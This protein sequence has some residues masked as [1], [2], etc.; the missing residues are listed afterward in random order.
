MNV[1]M[2]EATFGSEM[3]R[4]SVERRDRKTLSI[5]VLP[6]QTVEVLAPVDAS[7]ERIIERVRRRG[8]WI[9][10]QLRYFDQFQPRTP[11]RRYLAGETHLYLGRQYKLKVLPGIRNLVKMQRGQIIIWSTR[12]QR[13]EQTR[14]LMR[15]WFLQR[16]RVKFAERLTISQNRFANPERMAPHGLVIRDLSHRWGSMTKRRNLVLNRALIGASTEAIDYVITHELCHIEHP[17][18]GREFFD[19]L[20]RVMPDWEKRKLKLERQ[21]A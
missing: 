5:S 8:A 7:P 20:R 1:E 15:D 2:L 19:L 12:A 9:R 11:D 4:F 14:Q 16:A 13:E 6:D 3:I 17:H 10:K 18:H 21:M